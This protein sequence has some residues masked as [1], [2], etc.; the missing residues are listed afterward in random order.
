MTEADRIKYLRKELLGLTLSEFGRRIDVSAGTLSPIETGKNPVSPKMRRAICAAYNVN[1]R[2]LLH[3]EGDI[4]APVDR[5]EKLMEW[6]DR[7]LAETPEP[8][9]F[10]FISMLTG[11]PD[12]W[13][14]ALEAKALE[15][16]AE[17]N[18]A[19]VPDIE[20][21]IEAYRKE[22]ELEKSRAENSYQSHASGE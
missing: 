20:K 11:L 18:P 13:W 10:K 15:I 16:L 22:L 19:A 2:W 7:A 8:F 14:S 21:E 5:R 4:F 6:A 9:R 1:E 17:E 12:E 3:G